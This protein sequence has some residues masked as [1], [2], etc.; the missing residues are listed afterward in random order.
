MDTELLRYLPHREM[1]KGKF[2]DKTFFWSIVFTIRP[3][4]ATKYY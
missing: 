3:F 4:W 2:P 1:D